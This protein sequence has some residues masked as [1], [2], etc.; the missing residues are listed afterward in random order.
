MPQYSYFL[1]IN[2]LQDSSQIPFITSVG[3]NSLGL[4]FIIYYSKKKIVQ[5]LD[6]RVNKSYSKI[7]IQILSMLI[8]LAYFEMLTFIIFLS[9]MLYV[10]RKMQTYNNFKDDIEQPNIKIV[11]LVCEYSLILSNLG[12]NILSIFQVYEW[13]IQINMIVF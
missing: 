6:K 2:G 10:Q 3:I 12:S 11:F 8:Y 4:P 5:I 13:A 7:S 1:T 9:Q